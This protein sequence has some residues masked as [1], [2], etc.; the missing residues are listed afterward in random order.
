MELDTPTITRVIP[1][2]IKRRAGFS[3]AEPSESA[4]YVKLNRQTAC[5]PPRA[6]VSVSV[7]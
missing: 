3:A 7:R 6:A 2:E 1:M 4:A 5:P